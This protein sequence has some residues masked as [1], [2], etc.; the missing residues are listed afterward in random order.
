M[1]HSIR[2]FDDQ[3]QR[4]VRQNDFAL[5]PFETLALGFLH[6][7]VLDLGCGLGN[8]SIEAARLGCSVLSI[9][10]S[11]TAIGRI[12]QA[13]L[14]EDLPIRAEVADLRTYKIS[15][16][17]DAVVCIGLLMFMANDDAVRIIGEIQ[18]QLV[19]GGV[20]IINV[21]IEGT[22][23][24]EMFGPDPYYLFGHTEMQDRFAG[25]EL[26]ES[27]YDNFEAPGATT[28]SFATVVARKPA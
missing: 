7:R 9:D 18:A 10:G 1:H 15:G 12:R 28:K 8:L 3:F 11:P 24:L 2:F 19:A 5:N 27:R 21:L 26:I 22:T 13:A 4:Q 23:Y 14:D 17:F 6:G 20:A 16:D 25:W